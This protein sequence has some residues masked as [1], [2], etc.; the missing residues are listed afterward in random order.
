VSSFAGRHNCWHFLAGFRE[1]HDCGKGGSEIATEVLGD[2]LGFLDRR[3]RSDG[4]FLHFNIWDPH[5]PYRTP[6]DFGNPFEHDPV[7]T[8]VTQ[9]MIERQRSTWGTHSA[10]APLHTPGA[11][12]GP[13]DVGTI[14]DLR[15]YKKWIDGYDTGIRFADASVGRL[16]EKLDELG[17]AADTAV[18]VTADH[19]E[20]QGELGVYGDHQSA[21]LITCRIPMILKWPGI[22]PRVDGALHYQFDVAATVVELLGLEVPARWDARG[23]KAALLAGRE[24]GREAIVT[25]QGCWSCQ[26]G[27]IWDDWILL[28]TY[29][30]GLKD[31]PPVMLFDRRRDP[32]ELVDQAEARPEVVDRGLAVLM[33]WI[34]EQMAAA[35]RK[36]DPLQKVIAEGG[37][38]HTRGR[39]REYLDF[40]R[41]TGRPEIA[42]R[43]EKRYAGVKGY[44]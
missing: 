42:E 9:E 12:S 32:H 11:V 4:W 26:R 8:W 10:E 13:R 36:E 38:F 19:G 43:M 25:T 14:R 6:A 29:M 35:D 21:D 28:R 1:V 18:V 5:T 41:G 7:A 16:L 2:A 15:D 22:A 31:W 17:I 30:D 27:V 3:G 39:I 44:W 37:P 23:F 34:D 20:N 40:Y 24:Q 33:K